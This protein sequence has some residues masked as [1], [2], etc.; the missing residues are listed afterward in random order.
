M[1]KK[2]PKLVLN[3]IEMGNRKLKR[4]LKSETN[5]MPSHTHICSNFQKVSLGHLRVAV[6]AYSRN[7]WQHPILAKKGTKNFP[8]PYSIPFLSVLHENK[9]LHNFLEWGQRATAV[10]I[11]GLY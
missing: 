5:G 1:V 7:L 2:E 9:V 4:V 8:T 6:R 11:K 10:R 3:R